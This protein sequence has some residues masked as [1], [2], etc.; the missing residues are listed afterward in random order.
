MKKADPKK[1]LKTKN[2]RKTIIISAVSISFMVLVWIVFSLISNWKNTL[3]IPELPDL[4]EQTEI[5]QNHFKTMYSAAMKR[6]T[7]DQAIGRLGMTFHANAYYEEAERCYRR[8]M[9]LNPGK[10][11]WP[12]YM[13]LIYEELG[14][15]QNARSNLYT[16]I[17]LNP[18]I[19]QAWF[20]LGH[21][22]LK[23]NDYQRAS[24]AFKKVLAKKLFEIKPT[25]NT[26]LSNTGAFPLKAYAKFNI[27]RIEFELGDYDKSQQKV[28]ELNKNYPTFGPVYNLQGQLYFALGHQGKA[29]EYFLRAADLQAYLPPADIIYD[30][31]ILYS[32]RADIL[33]KQFEIAQRGQCNDWALALNKLIMK[34]KPENKTLVKALLQLSVELKQQEAVDVYGQ[35]FR[36]IYRYD[37][38][39]LREMARFLISREQYDLALAL[40]K[41]IQDR[42]PG[43]TGA[44]M[45]YIS[46]LRNKKEYQKAEDYCR[47]VLTRQPNN[48]FVR[49]ALARILISQNRYKEAEDQLTVVKKIYPD[50]DA[51]LL[52]RARIWRGK[53]NATK[54]I[55]YYEKYLQA[56]PTNIA[57]V[58][59][60]GNYY[61]ALRRW[62]TAVRYFETKLNSSPNHPEFVERNAWILGACPDP[63]YRNV[64][65]ASAFAERLLVIPK[66]SREFELRSAM[67]VAVIYAAAQEFE[68][69]LNIVNEYATQLQKKDVAN[70]Y[71][72]FKTLQKLFEAGK[73]YRI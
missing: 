11:R 34:C 28:N 23:Q 17:T 42:N 16:V 48:P 36:E 61:I 56:N 18:D 70:Y 19:S 1:T 66:H 10:W 9:Q 51:L 50:N 69:A 55:E 40:I 7:S 33:I 64:K 29:E 62:E 65:K 8:A 32:R 53:N 26:I 30:D 68:K 63:R 15:S 24:D 52:L 14:D 27:A 47:S 72:T 31:L 67:T 58:V 73:P 46:V 54:S 49:I 5:L 21:A 45:E 39:G 37:E 3:Y 38:N 2:N 25:T 44:H 20:R 71:D 6:P 22:L 59:E 13:A 41:K 12:Y 60:L 43:S 35:V 57:Y 4:S